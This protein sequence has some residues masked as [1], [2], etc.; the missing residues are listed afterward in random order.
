MRTQT[1]RLS[2]INTQAGTQMRTL[3]MQAVGE[4]AAA[5]RRG[6]R[7]PPL[8]AYYYGEEQKSEIIICSL[9]LL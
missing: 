5:M 6:E 3:D 4:Y 9:K 8:T 2:Q 7:F 1:L